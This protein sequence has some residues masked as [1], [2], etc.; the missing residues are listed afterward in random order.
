MILSAFGA[1]LI[2]IG[3]NFFVYLFM[4]SLLLATQTHYNHHHHHHFSFIFHCHWVKISADYV[5]LRI[6]NKVYNFE[7]GQCAFY[8]IAF[9][10]DI[11]VQVQTK[12]HAL[13]F[14]SIFFLLFSSKNVFIS[15]L[16]EIIGKTGFF[17]KKT[18]PWD[19]K[20][21]IIIWINVFVFVFFFCSKFISYEVHNM[22]FGLVFTANSMKCVHFALNITYE[23][24]CMLK[25]YTII[26][27][28]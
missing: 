13:F 16:T 6:S 26:K 24:S 14:R 27:A 7:G 2:S 22:V 19:R 1:Q 9:C 17:E 23:F 12:I 3:F 21:S 28:M 15:F 5:C 4:Y 18:V 25:I 8:L 20:Q 11:G 10:M